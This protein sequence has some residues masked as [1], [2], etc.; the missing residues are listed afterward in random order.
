MSKYVCLPIVVLL[1]T[2]CSQKSADDKAG[3]EGAAAAPVQVAAAKR[4]AIHSFVTAEA[5]LYPLKQANVVPKISAPVARFLVQ[6]GD[7]VRQG[8]L[9]AVLEDRDL[10]ATAQESKQLYEQAQ[11]AYENTTQATMPDDL[12][13]A[14][15]DVESAR[16]ALDA[17][18]RVYDNRQALLRQGALAQKLV[19][20]AKVAL[21]Q[22]Q[23]QFE[24]AQQHLKSL[25]T[26]GRTEQVKSAQAQE[27]AAKAHYENAQ[28]QVSYAEVRS[29]M[30]GVISDRPINVG[31]M[32]SSG[33][34]LVSIVDL[35]RV[36]ARASVPVQQTAAL[37]VSAPAT[38]SG[39]GG[40]LTG[41]V[42]VVSPAVDPNTTTIQVWVEAPNPGER[43]KLGSTV[44]ISIDA[45]AIPNAIVVPLPALLAS[46]EGGEKVM[47]AGSDGLAHERPVKTGVRSGDDVQILDGVKEGEQ[48]I[49]Q[50][51]LG[52][53]DKAKIEVTKPGEADA[54]DK[55][56]EGGAK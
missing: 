33:S 13:K 26:V 35:S 32:A 41:K 36:V 54:G 50:G 37:K 51:G 44:Q 31:E 38:I 11:A 43:L 10:L 22:A 20:D 6:R 14:K 34:A 40:E 23:S 16:Q 17:A 46:D 56:E 3:G 39:A 45:G 1:L 30:N 49:T 5:V 52:L 12:T 48:V 2:G 28:A 21:V 18:Q 27:A 24:T 53:D 4:T 7:H 19:D 8:Q 29:P 42:T 9:L 47:V 55:K 25:Q 15:T